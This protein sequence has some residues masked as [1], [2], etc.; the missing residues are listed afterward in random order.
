MNKLFVL[1]TV[2]ILG[3]AVSVSVADE[4]FER[5]TVTFAVA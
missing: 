3:I 4:T 5:A 1:L 2:L